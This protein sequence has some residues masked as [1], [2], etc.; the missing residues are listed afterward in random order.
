MRGCA[1]SR[2]LG[3]GV[4]IPPGSWQSVSCDFFVIFYVV[5]QTSLSRND[6]SSLSVVSW[7]EQK[8]L[9]LKLLSS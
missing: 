9:L 4:R 5:R 3:L 2:L 8:E 1:P 6:H 7:K